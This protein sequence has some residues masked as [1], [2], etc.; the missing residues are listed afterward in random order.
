M[1][2]KYFSNIK[3][4]TNLNIPFLRKL[5]DRISETKQTQVTKCTTI[6]PKKCNILQ[7]PIKTRV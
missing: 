5:P 1:V 3:A 7:L 6:K 2:Y 4:T